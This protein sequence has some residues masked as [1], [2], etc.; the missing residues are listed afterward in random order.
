L[1][2][3]KPVFGFDNVTIVVS[4]LWNPS[5][6]KSS[7]KVKITFIDEAS[8]DPWT[9]PLSMADSRQRLHIFNYAT[10]IRATLFDQ[11]LLAHELAALRSAISSRLILAPSQT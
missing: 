10:S 3:V 2:T 1:N 5:L 6:K 11:P 4:R 9:T 7:E 8:I